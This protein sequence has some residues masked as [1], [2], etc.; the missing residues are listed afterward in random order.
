MATVLIG[1]AINTGLYFLSRAL[2]PDVNNE[3]PRLKEAQITSSAE[4][5]SI[6]RLYGRMRLGGNLIWAS[7]FKEK[8]VVTNQSSGGKGGGPS[9]TNT[10]YT[11]SCSFAIAF[12][13]GGNGVQ[14]GRVWADGKILDLSKSTVRFYKGTQ[15]QTADSIMQT[16]EGTANVPAY[17]GIT[18]PCV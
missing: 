13:E 5:V 12:G 8:K 11:Y 1:L 7:K 18:Y 15:T 14:L 6:P 16:I 4:G 9:V 10:T 17:R 3:G 2:A